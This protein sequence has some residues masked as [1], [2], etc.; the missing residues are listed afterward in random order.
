MPG[1]SPLLPA[2]MVK[3]RHRGRESRR[4]AVDRRGTSVLRRW[5]QPCSLARVMVPMIWIVLLAATSTPPAGAAPEVAHEAAPPAVEPLSA[6]RDD[7][8]MDQAWLAP[9]ALTQPARTL[10]IDNHELDV[11]GA[12]YAVFERWQVTVA[13]TIYPAGSGL[14]AMTKVRALDMGRY[15]AALLAGGGKLAE[16]NLLYGG[17]AASA[18]LDVACGVVVSLYGI[19]GP[20]V[21]TLPESGGTNYGALLL[22][23]GASAIL[24]VARRLKVVTEVDVVGHELCDTCES[25]AVERL[26]AF[27]GAR[28]HG[29]GFA[30]TLGA[31]VSA[32][33]YPGDRRPWAHLSV[34]PA[35]SLT[36]RFGP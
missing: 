6:R 14:A 3:V 9:T 32:R 20:H 18:C 31:A 4:S 13:G 22:T 25:N 36:Y 33:T 35:G 23:Y 27:A 7:S 8:A 28:V 5:P 24:P 2:R 34:L 11:V 30:L 1:T 15:H 29:A 26:V 21:R 17:A 10:T 19:A 12:T 16:G